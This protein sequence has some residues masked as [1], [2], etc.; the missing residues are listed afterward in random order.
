MAG[1][2]GLLAVGLAAVAVGGCGSSSTGTVTT[3]TAPA[4]PTGS[5][6]STGSAPAPTSATEPHA[7]LVANLDAICK[8]GNKQISEAKKA[9]GASAE[10]EAKAYAQ[11][12]GIYRATIPKFEALSPS[13]ADKAAFSRYLAAVKRQAGVIDRVTAHLRA[14][15]TNGL[16][17]L[18]KLMSKY[19]EERVTAAIDLGA[20]AC[21]SA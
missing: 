12:L 13:S 18:T 19:G 4:S 17:E 16:E 3:V 11:A 6:A 10:T 21:G 5:T 8:A 14:G 1:G 20:E 2:R 15:E 7:T 9:E